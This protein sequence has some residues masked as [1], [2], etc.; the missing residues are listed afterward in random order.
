MTKKIVSR[1][2]E[3]NNEVHF[4]LQIRKIDGVDVAVDLRFDMADTFLERAVLIID[5]SEVFDVCSVDYDVDVQHKRLFTKL[6][7]VTK[8]ST[9]LY[10][11]V[12]SILLECKTIVTTIKFSK[13]MG[14]FCIEAPAP[15]FCEAFDISNETG[16]I[17]IFEECCVCYEKTI[18]LTSCNHSLCI[19]C[20]SKTRYTRDEDGDE[21]KHCPVCRA[22]IH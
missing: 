2:I 6:F 19:P 15:S 17:S 13:L 18:T 5:S 21:V 3:S 8:D 11:Q 22:N 14:V 7:K 1:L 9:Q 4:D 10:A 20:W 12:A 16:V